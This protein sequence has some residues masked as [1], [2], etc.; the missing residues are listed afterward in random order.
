MPVKTCA[1]CKKSAYTNTVNKKKID[2]WLCADC[3]QNFENQAATAVSQPFARICDKCKKRTGTC[4]FSA[5]ERSKITACSDWEN[6][7]T[8]RNKK[9]W[10]KFDNP[11]D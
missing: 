7:N 4:R 1:L 10:A 9:R 6:K 8:E 5:F 2:N 3:R 11:P